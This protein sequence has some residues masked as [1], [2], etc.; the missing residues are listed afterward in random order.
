MLTFSTAVLFES[1]KL[2][3]VSENKNCYRWR[4]K[5]TQWTIKPI[6]WCAEQVVIFVRGGRI[7]GS[8]ASVTALKLLAS[9]KP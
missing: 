6:L 5:K 1:V 9:L 7:V 2:Y 3:D 8:V 4:P